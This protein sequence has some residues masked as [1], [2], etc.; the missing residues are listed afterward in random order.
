[1]V[2]KSSDRVH[3]YSPTKTTKLNRTEAETQM[4]LNPPVA[5]FDVD[6]DDD[7]FDQMV[8]DTVNGRVLPP[9]SSSYRYSHRVSASTVSSMLTGCLL[10]HGRRVVSRTSAR[11]EIP[12]CR[13]AHADNNAQCTVTGSASH[14]PLR[15]YQ[16]PC[17][18]SLGGSWRIY[19]SWIWGPRDNERT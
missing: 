5:Q 14:F 15:M 4:L 18:D 10:V 13:R 8:P 17:P 2:I 16:K 19:P 7:V 1:M 6:D 11:S 9:T 12:V 3:P